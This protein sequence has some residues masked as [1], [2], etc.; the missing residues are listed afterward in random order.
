VTGDPVNFNDPQGLLEE[1]D[2][3]AV[4]PFSSSLCYPN[5]DPVWGGYYGCGSYPSYATFS[6]TVSADGST[7]STSYFNAL[8]AAR[9]AQSTESSLKD[10]SNGNCDTLLG[11]TWQGLQSAVKAE[12]FKDGTESTATMVSLF[13]GSSAANQQN[14]IAT[15]GNQ[16]IQYYLAH[17][18][19]NAAA[20]SS[21]GGNLVFLD[22]LNFGGAL[23]VTNEAI[24]MHE[25]LHNATGLT[26]MQIQG[27]L[28]LAAGSS[29]NITNAV[30]NNCIY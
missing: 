25:A 5:Y 24:L 18:G 3:P 21:A 23:N 17:D 30:M 7:G 19:I 8:R 26:D 29:V 1:S 22:Y 10:P 2:G 4:N 12:N 9:Q 27:L 6:V 15:Y 11:M 16:T 28:N 20:V 13:A 14:A